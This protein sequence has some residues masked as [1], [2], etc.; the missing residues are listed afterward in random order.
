MTSSPLLGL[1]VMRSRKPNLLSHPTDDALWAHQEL[2]GVNPHVATSLV[3]ILDEDGIGQRVPWLLPV[4]L[5]IVSVHPIQPV[6][7]TPHMPHFGE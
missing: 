4:E 3:C 7:H 6:A 2:S 5:L 1:V